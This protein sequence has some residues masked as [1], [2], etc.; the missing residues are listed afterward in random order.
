MLLAS[1]VPDHAMRKAKQRDA[2]ARFYGTQD[3]RAYRA[4]CWLARIVPE[5]NT[6]RA[7]SVLFDRRYAIRTEIL[8]GGPI[9]KGV[10]NHRQPR[11]G[12]TILGTRLPLFVDIMLGCPEIDSKR[13]LYPVVE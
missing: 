9:C 3:L 12:A 5:D 6:V 13:P 4:L 2:R 11:D 1:T 8:R 7:L 10:L